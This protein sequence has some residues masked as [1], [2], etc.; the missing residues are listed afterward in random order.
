MLAFFLSCNADG[1]RWHGKLYPS[2]SKLFIEPDEKGKLP[3]FENSTPVNFFHWRKYKGKVSC[4]ND[5]S[6]LSSWK[7]NQKE[8]RPAVK[9][10]E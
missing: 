5:L 7:Y 4:V 9:K 8:F 6:K 10:Q 1:A 3:F 2:D